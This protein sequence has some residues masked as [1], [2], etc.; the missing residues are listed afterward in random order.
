MED[1]NE[2]ILQTLGKR[3]KE[4]RKSQKISQSQLAFEA[5]IPREQI[6][7]IEKGQ[8]NTTVKTLNAI[9]HALNL[10]LKEVFDF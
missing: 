3:I 7:R 1:A 6:I 2:E 8:I 4:L 9:A 10:K 5:G